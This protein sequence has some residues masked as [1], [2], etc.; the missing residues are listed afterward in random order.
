[1]LYQVKVG[2]LGLEEQGQ[3]YAQL[4]KHHIKDVTLMGAVGRT[5]KE[6]LIA[7]NELYLPYVY[8]DEKAIMQNHEIDAVCIFGDSTRKPLLAIAAIEA[9]KHVFIADPVGLNLEDAESVHK[10][11]QSRP[12]Q[13][14]M[15]SSMV[16]FDAQLNTVK[17][18]IDRGDI[19]DIKN[20]SLNSA[21]FSG[22]NRRYEISS[23]SNIL[24]YALDE[25]ELC[26]WL[27]NE[28]ITKISV[29]KNNDTFLCEGQTKRFSSLSLIVQPESNM[30]KS[31]VKIDGSKGQIV[32]SNT[33]NRS[34]KLY[35]KSGEKTN[36]YHN[37]VD[38]FTFSEYLQLHHFG[39]TV[40][41]RKRKSANT[42]IAVD[43]LKLALAFENAAS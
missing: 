18:V 26:L 20:I 42:E 12:S 13:Y 3:K 29:T 4:L 2:I 9:G 25:I 14:V 17:Q 36:I 22:L 6:L 21:F 11:A 1:M 31:I 30:E 38:G 37:N 41:G 23:G 40:L 35:S 15:V 19:G 8:S 10:C 7:K 27:L 5:Q 16:Q 28:P 24:D 39:Q 33:N 43:V 32:V 34:F